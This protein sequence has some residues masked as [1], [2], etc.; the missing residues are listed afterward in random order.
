[1]SGLHDKVRGCIIGG[2]LG[3][4]LGGITEMMHYKTIIQTFGEITDLR[5][6]GASH[7]SARFDANLPPGRFTDDTR[8]KH[9][10]INGIAENGGPMTADQFGR[11]MIDHLHGWYFTPVVNAYNKMFVGA[12]RPR[13]AGRGNMGSNST[14][15][16]IAPV[17]VINAGRPAAAAANAYDMASV[18]H[19]AYSL[20][21][22]AAVAAGV[23]AGMAA[24]ST[25]ESV[26]EAALTHIDKDAELRDLIERAVALARASG[27]YPEFREKFYDT[28]LFP[29]PQVDLAGQN[30]VPDG[31][32]DTAE[33]RE[34]IPAAFGL[35][36]LAGGNVKDAVLYA[37]N[38]GRD[39]DTIGSIVGGLSGAIGGASTIPAEWIEVLDGANDVTADFY[40]EALEQVLLSHYGA[41]RDALTAVLSM[42]G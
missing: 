28:C 15:M 23:A 31:F 35:L 16:A 14:A 6:T 22:A 39:A 33:P 21:A 3:D 2:T 7:D 36:V 12:A 37:A 27:G 41:E 40:V 30:P 29:W 32:Y 8:L 26:V 18:I 19:E 20:D 1:M 9:M 25:T 13:V 11:Y 10:I 34:T 24:G 5:A 4:S 38:F 17:G 42:G